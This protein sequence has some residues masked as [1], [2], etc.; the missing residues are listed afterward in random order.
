MPI[1]A[2]FSSLKSI[3]VCVRDSAVAPKLKYFPFS[4][5]KFGISQYFFRIGAQVLPS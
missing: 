3:F 2:K 4:C 5:N 1:P